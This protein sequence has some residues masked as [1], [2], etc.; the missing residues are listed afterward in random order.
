M[1]VHIGVEN[2]KLENLKSK[3]IDRCKGKVQIVAFLDN[4]QE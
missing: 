2:S 1:I 3:L 4:Q